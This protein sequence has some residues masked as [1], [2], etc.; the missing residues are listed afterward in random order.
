MKLNIGENLRRLR[1]AADMTQEQLADKLGVAYQSV[2]RWENGTTYPDM[3][4]L[5]VLAGIFGVTVD[6]LLGCEDSL[7]K[8][9]LEKRLEELESLLESAAPDMARIMDIVREVRRACLATPSLRDSCLG[10][11][12]FCF[13]YRWRDDFQACPELISELRMAFEEVMSNTASRE[14][15]DNMVRWMA[16]MEDEA[17][18]ESFLDQNAT[19]WDLSRD[20]LL[21][22]RYK[23]RGWYE[24]EEMMRQKILFCSLTRLLGGYLLRIGEGVLNLQENL[25]INMTLITFLHN[26]CGMVPDPAHPIT[27]DGTVD[28][29]APDRVNLGIRRACYLAATGDPEG[30]FT[31]LEDTVTLLEKL[32]SLQAGSELSC[33]SRWLRDFRLRVEH[34]VQFDQ[35]ELILRLN[36][37][38]FGYFFGGVYCHTLLHPLTAESGWEWFDP[39]RSDPRFAAYVERVKAVFAPVVEDKP[40]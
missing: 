1:R 33:S 12:V 7:Q 39:I 4:F 19:R 37:D 17:N 25:H 11:L 31:A 5:P 35:R 27:G 29:F 28:I 18:I 23:T 2:S 10:D 22:D 8:E 9:K 30:A 20:E 40:E 38:P 21:Y 16:Y 14:L 36:P 13:A 3:E 26:F 24:Q 6:E 32:M 15:K 34:S